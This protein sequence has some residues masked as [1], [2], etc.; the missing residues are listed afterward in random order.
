MCEKPTLTFE[1][2]AG[3]DSQMRAFWQKRINEM[4]DMAP[5]GMTIEDFRKALQSFE[6]ESPE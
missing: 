2:E 3:D 4:I 5:P 1:R 6:E